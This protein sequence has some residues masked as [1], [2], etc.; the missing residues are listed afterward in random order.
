MQE[1]LCGGK[2]TEDLIESKCFYLKISQ[3]HVSCSNFGQVHM[4]CDENT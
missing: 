2:N 1:T 3:V 4:F